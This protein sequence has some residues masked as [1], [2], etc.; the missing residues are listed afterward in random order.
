MPENEPRQD[1]L[2]IENVEIEP[3]SD[4]ALDSVAGGMID[5]A[6]GEG[7]SCCTC[8]SCYACSG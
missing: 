2:G 4:E 3:L 1:D 5:A 8:C 7:D 6:A